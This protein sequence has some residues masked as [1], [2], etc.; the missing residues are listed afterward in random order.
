MIDFSDSVQV[1]Q[2]AQQQ[3]KN[4]ISCHKITGGGVNYVYR[5][6][7]PDK[8]LV[9]KQYPP[10]LS[11]DT[12][13][14]YSQQRYFVEK[15][16]LSTFHQFNTQFVKVP[17][18]VHFIDADYVLV[19]EDGGKE[20]VSLEDYFL[21]ENNHLKW[22]NLHSQIMDFFV[23]LH[24]YPASDAP[25][26]FIN[27]LARQTNHYFHNTMLN[28]PSPALKPFQNDQLPEFTNHSNLIMGDFWPNSICLNFKTNTIYIVDWETARF[29][30]GLEDIAQC[31]GNLW[32]MAQ[33]PNKFNRARV[34]QFKS[35]MVN[36]Y[37]MKTGVII[38]RRYKI[39]T[40]IYA[41]YLARYP[42]WAFEDPDEI[43]SK[44]VD[45]FDALL[46]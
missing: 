21:N 35:D 1:L 13:Y 44:A 5:L 40:L 30:Y 3:F 38:E 39:R 18:L 7:F 6:T 29:G 17:K 22:N 24:Q 10:H 28:D 43:I 33:K 23:N 27:P 16:V 19:M 45:A 41:V 14:Q 32:L 34:L 42:L 20:I 2:Y 25:D 31:C 46:G 15:Q 4:V 36:D 11:S 9:L 12:T 37:I 26:L 8:S